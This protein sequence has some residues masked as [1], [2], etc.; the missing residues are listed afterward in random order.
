MTNQSSLFS[1]KGFSGIFIGLL[2]LF[3]VFLFHM[4]TSNYGQSFDGFSQLPILFIE[5]GVIIISVILIFGA[6]MILWFRAKKKGRKN[7]IKLWSSISKKQRFHL[8]TSTFISILILIC[9]AYLGYYRFITPA[10][11]IFFGCLLLNLSRFSS[12]SLI[13]LAVI[14]ISIGILSYFILDNEIAFL[15]LGIGIFPLLYGFFTF[16]NE[17]KR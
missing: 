16:Q 15:S 11:L 3:G 8:L 10:L 14:E 4:M 7:N 17:K 6:L 9:I 2:G 5:I 13:P 1:L 12:R